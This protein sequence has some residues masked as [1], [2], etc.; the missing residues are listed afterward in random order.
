M[1]EFNSFQ[2]VASI[3]PMGYKTVYVYDGS[4][5]CIEKRKEA[6]GKIE[7]STYHYDSLQR[8]FMTREW[9]DETTFIAKIEERDFLN[10]VVE[11]RSEYSTGAL[12]SKKRYTYDIRGNKIEEDSYVGLDSFNRDQIN[13]NGD[14]LVVFHEDALGHKTHI[15]YEHE[16]LNE[17][18]QRVLQWAIKQLSYLMLLIGSLLLKADLQRE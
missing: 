17:I 15:S 13:F 9:I 14:D 12:L 3:D 2:R 8:L 11:E 5:R 18:G 16:F 6:G 10:R 4:G 1:E 7:R